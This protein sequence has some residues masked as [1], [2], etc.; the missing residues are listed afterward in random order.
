[1]AGVERENARKRKWQTR[2]AAAEKSLLSIER[3]K[4]RGEGIW[5][6]ILLKTSRRDGGG[7]QIVADLPEWMIEDHSS[8]LNTTARH[9]ESTVR[10]RTLSMRKP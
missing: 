8:V 10:I 5:V 3:G 9:A 7:D 2:E 4:S 6:C 1:M